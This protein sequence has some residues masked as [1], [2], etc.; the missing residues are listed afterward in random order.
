MA[1]DTGVVPY[2]SK[3]VVSDLGLI[4]ALAVAPA[5][6]V[7]LLKVWPHF[8]NFDIAMKLVE[9]AQFAGLAAA[10]TVNR[11]SVIAVTFL[12]C[13]VC[14]FVAVYCGLK[15]WALANRTFGLSVPIKAAIGGILIVAVAYIVLSETSSPVHTYG[16]MGDSVFSDTLGKIPHCPIAAETPCQKSVLHLATQFHHVANISAMLAGCLLLGMAF[17]L[18][19]GLSN[20]PDTD[21]AQ[22]AYR[23][24]CEARIDQLNTL[25]Y[26]GAAMLLL[27]VLQSKIEFSWPLPFIDGDAVRSNFESVVLS[28]TSVQGTI[29]TMLLASFYIPTAMYLSSRV[30]HPSVLAKTNASDPDGGD[31]APL[32]KIPIF[33]AEVRRWAARILGLLTPLLASPVATFLAEIFA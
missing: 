14:A 5:A 11:Y 25:L 33:S 3:I 28:V 10:E 12:L 8:G 31:T 19:M 7:V 27:G 20:V 22:A 29:F 21:D 4:A 9:T 32:P 30:N 17:F 23:K 16:L 18:V 15:M 26:L 24:E 6:M 13:G 1:D 2:D